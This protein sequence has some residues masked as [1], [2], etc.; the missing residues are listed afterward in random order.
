MD[1]VKLKLLYPLQIQPQTYPLSCYVRVRLRPWLT[2]CE[3]QA[4]PDLY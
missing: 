2:L 1:F 3:T 4:T